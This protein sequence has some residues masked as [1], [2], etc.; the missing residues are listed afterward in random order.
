M[1]FKELRAKKLGDPEFRDTY[2]KGLSKD[3][4]AGRELRDFLEA[5]I[6]EIE[7]GED[8]FYEAIATYDKKINEDA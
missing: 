2:I 8:I 1:D 3:V 5:H 4:F 6:R 7:T